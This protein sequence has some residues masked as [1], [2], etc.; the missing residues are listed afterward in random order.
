MKYSHDKRA[1]EQGG[2]YRDHF[3]RLLFFRL[4]NLEHHCESFMISHAV[5]SLLFPQFVQIIEL[6]FAVRLKSLFIHDK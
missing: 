3:L 6:A 4:L 5:V 2:K 1:R